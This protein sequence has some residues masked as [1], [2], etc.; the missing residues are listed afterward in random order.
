MQMDIVLLHGFTETPSIWDSI[1]AAF[2]QSGHRV[3]APALAGN[4]NAF[5]L[6]HLNMSM[7]AESV[8]DQAN[9]AGMSRFMVFGHSMGGYVALQMLREYPDQIIGLGLVQSSASADKEEKKLGRTQLSRLL[10]AKGSGT[11]LKSFIP[12]LF[13]V[14]NRERMKSVIENLQDKAQTISAKGLA[15]QTLAMRDRLDSLELLRKTK[16]PLLFMPGKLDPLIP[17]EVIESQASSC[18]GPK[19]IEIL[20]NSGHMG[21]FEEYDRTLAAMHNFIDFAVFHQ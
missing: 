11:F 8:K 12:E 19:L 17:L 14:S 16:T 10:T 13:A 21:I 15:A 5:Q 3:L 2:T 4:E 9:K 1:A 7:M 20:E 18:S 6:A